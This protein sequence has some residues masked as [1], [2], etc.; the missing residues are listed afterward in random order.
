MTRDDEDTGE[1]W[2]MAQKILALPALFA[3]ALE[4]GRFKDGDGLDGG[5]K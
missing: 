1:A 2:K 4:R 3:E 5:G